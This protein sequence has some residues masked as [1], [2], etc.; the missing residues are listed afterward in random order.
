MRQTIGIVVLA[1]LAGSAAADTVYFSDAEGGFNL[2][3]YGYGGAWYAHTGERGTFLTFCVELD[4]HIYINGTEY[5]YVV[6]PYAEKGGIADT[7]GGDPDKDYLKS[8]TKKIYYAFRTGVDLDKY[9]TGQAQINDVIQVAIWHLEEGI[10]VTDY[11]EGSYGEYGS[12]SEAVDGML[13]D[14]G[15]LN[16]PGAGRVQVMNLS[17]TYGEYNQDVLIII[18]LP[19]AAGLACAGLLGLAAVRRRGA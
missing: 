8:T 11:L 13:T 4:E 10:E 15:A 7:D 12:F 2:E 16:L 6:N 1:A 5:N 19:S 3:P 17:R 9:G 18:P 14:F